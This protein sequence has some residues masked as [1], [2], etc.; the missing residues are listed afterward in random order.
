MHDTGQQLSSLFTLDGAVQ[1]QFAGVFTVRFRCGFQLCGISTS[2]LSKTDGGFGWLTIGIESNFRWRAVEGFFFVGLLFFQRSD[3]HGKTARSGKGGYVAKGQTGVFQ[4]VFN[5][6][7][8]GGR[9]GVQGHGWQ[10]FGT[11]FD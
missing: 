7:G 6:L 2:A 5:A 10:F 9:Q 4:A 1:H 3:A 11:Q 8:K